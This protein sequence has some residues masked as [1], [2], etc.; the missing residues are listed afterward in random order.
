MFYVQYSLRIVRIALPQWPFN[1]GGTRRLLLPLLT[2]HELHLDE[3]LTDHLLSTV[4]G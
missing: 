1:L 4:G 3:L 2:H